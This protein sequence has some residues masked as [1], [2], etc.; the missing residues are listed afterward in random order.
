MQVCWGLCELGSGDVSTEV[1]EETFRANP[2][3][4]YTA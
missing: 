2:R 1:V 4:P 3:I